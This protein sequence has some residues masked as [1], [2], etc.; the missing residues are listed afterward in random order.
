VAAKDANEIA[1]LLGRM[2]DFCQD[3][4]LKLKVLLLGPEHDIKSD[5]LT[6]IA[7]LRARYSD[8]DWHILAEVGEVA[9]HLEHGTVAPD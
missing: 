5:A 3:R 6:M 7:S 2:H 8:S 4:N 1:N 9:F